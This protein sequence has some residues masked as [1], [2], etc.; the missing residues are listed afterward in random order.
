MESYVA[1]PAGDYPKDKVVLL[2]TDVFGIPLNNNKV[3]TP[4]REVAYP[5]DDLEDVV[6]LIGMTDSCSP[7]TSPEMASRL[8]SLTFSKET[9]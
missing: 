9:L 5:H 2:L 6:I 4:L 3:S 1:T 7:T 8:L